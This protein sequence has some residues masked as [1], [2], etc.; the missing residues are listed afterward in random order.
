MHYKRFKL[1]CRNLHL[2]DG[3]G[4]LLALGRVSSGGLLGNTTNSLLSGNWLLCV[5]GV[6]GDGC[7]GDRGTSDRGGS[8]TV[9]C[10]DTGSSL[11][12]GV[13]GGKLALSL[14]G[15]GVVLRISTSP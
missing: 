14:S 1:H 3:T 2:P 11:G 13:E 10:G 5:T 7:T 9:G 8:L 15:V 6:V 12:L 4:N